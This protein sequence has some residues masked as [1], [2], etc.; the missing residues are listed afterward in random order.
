MARAEDVGEPETSDDSISITSTASSAKT[1]RYEVQCIVAERR[2]K[3][4]ME[5]LTAWKDYPEHRHTWEPRESFVEDDVFSEWTRTK[6]RIS[7]G[8][9]KSFDVKAWK[10]RSKTIEEETL[11]RKKLRRDKRLRLGAQ[12]DLTSEPGTRD[13]NIESSGSEPAPRRPDKRIKRRSVHQDPP[14]SSSISEPS[15]ISRSKDN[16]RP[17]K[18]RQESEVFTPAAKWTQAET[19]TLE[20]GLRT[21]KGPRWKELL[22][23]YGRNGT[24]S[25][26]LKDKTPSDLYDKAKSVRQ[27]FV[28]SGR[29]PPEYL[30]PFSRSASSKGSGSATPTIYSQSK[31]QSRAASKKSSR[32][33][34]VD[35]MMAELHDKQQALEERSQENRRPQ[36][37][38]Y[39]IGTLP[40]ARGRE[41]ETAE[42]VSSRKPKAPKASQPPARKIEMSSGK[43]NLIENPRATQ[44]KPQPESTVPHTKG[45]T[46]AKEISKNDAS[47]GRQL[48]D[49]PQT[50]ELSKTNAIPQAERQ[51]KSLP[52]IAEETV[53]LATAATQPES[54]CNITNNN[55]L[56][57]ETARTTW[58]GTARAP[59]I[60]P[61][62]SNPSRLGAIGSGPIRTSKV[63][64]KFG[65]IEPKKPIMRGDVTAAWNAEPKK[66]NSNNWATTNAD[67]ANAQTSKRNYRLSVQNKIRKSRRDGRA[68]DPNSLILIDPKTGKAPSTVSA[69]SPTEMLSKTPLQLHQEELAAR[70]AEERRAQEAVPAPSP[71]A[72]LSKTPLQL[73]QEELAAREAEEREAQEADDLVHISADEHNTP[74]E[75]ID[76]HR[77]I[78][79]GDQRVSEN[80]SISNTVAS[81][82]KTTA[83]DMTEVPASTLTSPP[84][85]SPH[86]FIPHETPLGP[87][88]QTKKVTTISLQNYS[89][90][91][92]PSPHV[93]GEAVVDM[94]R[95]YSSDDPQ[96]F[97][98]RSCPSQEQKNEINK[99]SDPNL[100]IGDIKLGKNDEKNVNVKFVGF[101]FE[102]HKLLL[103]I[104]SMP[105]TM[106]FVFEAVCLASEYQVYFPAVSPWCQ[107]NCTY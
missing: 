103:T 82:L 78:R 32:S 5:Y 16:D 51:S 1:E 45:I 15:S 74:Q 7:R 105:R 50:E 48:K 21:L 95:P 2:T 28:D 97:T 34:S 57:E 19:I 56:R 76:Q 100:V 6:M 18:S 17:L 69:P 43:K 3:G 106:H 63:K 68:P 36:P 86:H 23:L 72:M 96:R 98:L 102:T 88:I 20:E 44:T 73:H 13:A 91:S 101:G 64:P 89:K 25:H 14:P 87:K 46:K 26:V 30:K 8:L 35:S 47:R 58:S 77:E 65:Q 42:K 9:E 10:K 22:S 92:I 62:V 94:H 31:V 93:L 55:A 67:P 66:R 99:M 80:G 11:L 79:I 83:D 41:Q 37:I 104:K 53:K 40:T 59:T 4:V 70:E 39:S 90:R 71:T 85:A 33:T 81:T 24:I 12:D 107:L 29:E 61:S 27:E 52:L 84:P 49:A 38:I 60:R 75:S 54:S